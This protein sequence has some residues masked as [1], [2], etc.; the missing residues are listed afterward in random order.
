MRCCR[1]AHR[2]GGR[3]RRLTLSSSPS[4]RLP[5]SL[6]STSGLAARIRPHQGRSTSHLHSPPR[7]RN[8]GVPWRKEEGGLRAGSGTWPAKP[9]TGPAQRRRRRPRVDGSLPLPRSYPRRLLPL[10]RG[11][12]LPLLILCT[13]PPLLPTRIVGEEGCSVPAMASAK[14]N[15][16]RLLPPAWAQ[17]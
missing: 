9:W 12:L 11:T 1:S 7:P 13:A 3:R 6:T 17:A 8:W 16:G 14:K 5:P 4:S 2:G 15:H 10:G